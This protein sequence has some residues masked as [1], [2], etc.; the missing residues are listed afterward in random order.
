MNAAGRGRGG[1]ARFLGRLLLLVI[2]LAL[3]ASMMLVLPVRAPPPIP[4][5][6]RGH[7]YDFS[8]APVPL[9]TP[10]RA[11]ID[12]MAYS[13]A[14]QVTD[15]AGSFSLLVAGNW[16]I[17]ATVAETP[18]VKEGADL[19][20]V[21][22]FAAGD[23]AGP[24]SVFQETIS[25]TPGSSVALDLHLSSPTTEAAGIK[26]QGI[27][28]QPARGGNQYVLVCNPTPGPVSL[29]DYY[30]QTDRPGTVYGPNVTLSGLLP[31]DTSIQVNL[32]TGSPLALRGDALKL[33]YRNPGGGG[34][35]AGGGDIVVDRVEYNATVGGTLFWEPGNTIL[36]DADAPRIGEI[37]ERTP[38]CSDTNSA[39]DFRIAREPG[40]PTDEG[41]VV[42]IVAPVAGQTVSGGTTFRIEWTLSHEIFQSSSL[43]VWVNVTYEGESHPLIAGEAGPMS[44]D[45]AVPDIQDEAASIRVT[46]VDPFGVETS[47]TVSFRI[48]RQQPYAILIAGVLIAVVLAFIV[49]ALYYSRRR[50]AR[51]PLGPTTAA[52]PPQPQAPTG[53]AAV[54]PPPTPVTKECPQCHA[55]VRAE[56]NSC[57]Y[58]GYVFPP[59]P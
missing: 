18:T 49:G 16:M 29:F 9:G 33:V 27:V 8:G 25:W 13:N 3:V 57:F 58:C 37:L 53:I 15:A 54:G 5:V 43:F 26:I 30:M 11:L 52:I 1:P 38:T 32:S 51:P 44:A 59:P 7:A 39:E 6:V 34:A 23:F 10:I 22:M 14:S 12:G 36:T 21:V 28:A 4:L 31:P 50:A 45:W 48:V 24:T 55:I 41:A 47:G 42:A 19:D 35:A 17:N 46:V 56:D 40:L 2:V 20:E